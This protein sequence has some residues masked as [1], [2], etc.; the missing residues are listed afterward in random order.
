MTRPIF[1][2]GNAAQAMIGYLEKIELLC[3]RGHASHT[4]G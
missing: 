2:H 4:V 1:M 3:M